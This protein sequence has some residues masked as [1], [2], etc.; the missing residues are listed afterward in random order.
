MGSPRLK[1]STFIQTRSNHLITMR[2]AFIAAFILGLVSANFNAAMQNAMQNAV[3]NAGSV[4]R[5]NP[6][7]NSVDTSKMID[8][9][10]QQIKKTME[11]VKS[12]TYDNQEFDKAVETLKK[13]SDDFSEIEKNLKETERKLRKGYNDSASG[14]LRYFVM[15]PVV[16]LFLF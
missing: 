4:L 11:D 9:A 13:E 2:L 5:N 6:K 14:C 8:T 3:Q 10:N 12:F 1:V 15:V 16:A 7:F